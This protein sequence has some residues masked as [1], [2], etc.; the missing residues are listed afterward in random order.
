MA[1][2]RDRY[3][4]LWRSGWLGGTDRSVL[5]GSVV[6][7]EASIMAWKYG[8][9]CP[10]GLGPTDGILDHGVLDESYILTD[11]TERFI[12]N[13]IFSTNLWQDFFSL[14]RLRRPFHHWTFCTSSYLAVLSFVWLNGSLS[15][16]WRAP[17]SCR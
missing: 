10:R 16:V 14:V 5:E 11:S 2:S 7:T 4:G 8:P 9:W 13:N 17:R 12:I 6:R 3:Y 15:L 1:S